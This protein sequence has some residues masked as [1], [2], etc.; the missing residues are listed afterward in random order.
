MLSNARRP[1]FTRMIDWIAQRKWWL[2]G[3]ILLGCIAGTIQRWWNRREHSQDAAIIAASRKY[4]VEPALVKAVVWRES[5]FDPYAKGTSGEVGLMQIMK[6][7]ANDWATA[8][9]R[10]LFSHQQLFDPAL[11]TDCGAWYLRKLLVRYR[12]TDHPVLYALAA[13]NAGPTRVNKWRHGA[14]ATNSTAFLAQM[15]FPGTRKY[16][17]TVNARYRDYRRTF[18]ASGK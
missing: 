17:L 16:V 1:K 5:W 7:T 13:Y 12:A 18:Q 14:A 8:Q 15:D 3:I 11:N 4:G 9:K 6:D 2:F 10:T